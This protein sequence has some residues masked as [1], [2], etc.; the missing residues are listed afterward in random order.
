[1]ENLRDLQTIL[2]RRSTLNVLNIDREK[3]KFASTIILENL[4]RQ[5]NLLH[6]CIKIPENLFVSILCLFRVKNV[7]AKTM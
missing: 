6:V 2:N 1:M 7:E 5:L 4:P 3:N